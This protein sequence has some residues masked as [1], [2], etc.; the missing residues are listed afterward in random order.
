M[1]NAAD[2]EFASAAAA[3]ALAGLALYRTDP[4]DGPVRLF[5]CRHGLFRQLASVADAHHFLATM[6]PPVER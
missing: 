1:T 4:R 2:K 6:A 5:C 3:F